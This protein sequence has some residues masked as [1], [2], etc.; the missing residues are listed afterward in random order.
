[1][2]I[3]A[4]LVPHQ[5]CYRPYPKLYPALSAHPQEET[6]SWNW[7]WHLILVITLG[8][9][10]RMSKGGSEGVIS[11]LRALRIQTRMEPSI[12]SLCHSQPSLLSLDASLFFLLLILNVSCLHFYVVVYILSLISLRSTAEI[13]LAFLYIPLYFLAQC[14]ACSKSYQVLTDWPEEVWHTF[15]LIP[16]FWI[17]PA[18]LLLTSNHPKTTGILIWL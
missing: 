5:I 7:F 8:Q 11:E 2:L 6:Q 13:C 12:L 14:L 17:L 3:Q 15:L 1:M 18:P 9:K 10:W 16:D 4:F